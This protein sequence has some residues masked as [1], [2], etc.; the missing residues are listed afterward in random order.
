MIADQIFANARIYTLDPSGS[1]AEAIA[2]KD[3]RIIAVGSLDDVRQSSG[4]S[5]VEMD[6]GGNTV[7]PG[8]IDSHCH[9]LMHGVACTRSANLSGCRSITELS[10]RL[11]RHREKNPNSPWLTGEGFDQEMFSDGRWIT[12][13]DLDKVSSEVPVMVIRLCYH[14]IVANSAALAPVRD[15][16]TSEQWKTGRLCEEAS[17]L[18]KNQVPD[19]TA[20]ELE[21]AALYAL[22]EARHAG[23]TSVHTQ[24]DSPE[25]LALIR[26]LKDEGKLP[27]RVRVQWPYSLMRQLIAEGLRTGSGDDWLRI[28]SIKLFMDGSMGARTCAMSEPFSDDPENRGK[29]LRTDKQLAQVLTRVQKNG[30]QAAVHAIGDL[31]ISST[32]GA[33]E[34]ALPYGNEGNHLRHRI[35]HV[36]IASQQIISDMA[37]L[38]IMAVIQP[39]FVIT[40][41]WTMERIGPE[42]YKWAYPFKTMLE[43]G[44]TLGMGSDCPVERLDPIELLHRAVNREPRSKA[45]CLTVEQTLRGYTNGSAYIGFEEK[46]KGSL[47]TGKLADFTVL[48][49]DPFKIDPS[50]LGSMRALGTVVGGQMRN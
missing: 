32:I 38:N 47:E 5:T 33:I 28:G 31:A 50:G 19:C 9:L 11:R 46:D 17:H 26:R 36:A 14:A 24:L 7:I 20:L 45:E 2:V 40:D 4:P 12:R 13:E 41:F 6:L 3:G 25:E 49:D 39:Q 21:T 8:C 44:I 30:F 15:K 22:N 1:F 35:E 37:R 27:V 42:R 23:L 48:S 10:D 18:V 34:R 29:L 43:A 16:L